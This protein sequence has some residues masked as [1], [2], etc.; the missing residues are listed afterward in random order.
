MEPVTTSIPGVAEITRYRGDSPP[1]LLIEVPHGA[2]ELAH[3]EALASRLRSPLPLGLEQFFHVNTD[4]GAPEIALRTASL[5][6]RSAREARTRGVVVVR[7]LVPRTFIDL[8]REI[9]EGAAAGMTPGLPPYITTVADRELLFSL[10]QQYSLAVTRAYEEVMVAGGLAVALHSYAPRSV[11]VPVDADIVR[12]LRAAYRPKVYSAWKLRPMVDLITADAE[13]RDLSP[14]GLAR[15]LRAAYAP[16]KIEVA[17]NATYQ[18]HPATMGYRH[19]ARYRGRVLCV[20][21]RRDLLGSPWRPFVPSLIGKRKAA[22]L[23]A[24]LAEAL[25]SA[26]SARRTDDG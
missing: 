19:A 21:Y 20:E 13:G 12:S 26:L 14:P 2:T 6:A 11:E 1:D 25:D 8:N 4:F 17:E 5:L 23:A 3:Y 15:A 24:P 10:Y 16:L 7:A 22:R 18:L 9:G